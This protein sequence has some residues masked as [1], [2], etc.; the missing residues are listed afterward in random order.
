MSTSNRLDFQTLGSQLVMPKH[1]PDHCIYHYLHVWVPQAVQG[2]GKFV[3]QRRSTWLVA[4]AKHMLNKRC[5]FS[6]HGWLLNAGL[7]AARLLHVHII[8]I[9][10]KVCRWSWSMIWSL[11]GGSLIATKLP[12]LPTA[13]NSTWVLWGTKLNNP[14]YFFAPACLPSRNYSCFWTCTKVCG[15]ISNI[16]LKATNI[17]FRSWSV[18][19]RVQK[20]IK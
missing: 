18:N 4:A 7:V 9:Q 16:V 14:I 1:L 19:K 13:F 3:S 10:K 2:P 15:L 12:K 17:M 8:Y 5:I 11:T 6:C 20:R